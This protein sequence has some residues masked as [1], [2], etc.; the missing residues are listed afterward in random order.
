MQSFPEN[1]TWFTIKIPAIHNVPQCENVYKF[2]LESEKLKD[3]RYT[4]DSSGQW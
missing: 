4:G 1:M 3:V 2:Y